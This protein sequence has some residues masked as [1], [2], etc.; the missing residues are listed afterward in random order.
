MR[1]SLLR[2]I[3]F[4]F[5]QVAVSQARATGLVILLFSTKEVIWSLKMKLLHLDYKKTVT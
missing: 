2:I 4:I 5:L 1:L 3:F